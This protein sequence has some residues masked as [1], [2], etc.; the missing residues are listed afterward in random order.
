LTGTYAVSMAESNNPGQTGHYSAGGDEAHVLADYPRLCLHRS[1]MRSF[2]RAIS[3][4]SGICSRVLK[5][6]RPG[7]FTRTGLRVEFKSDDESGSRTYAYAVTVR[8]AVGATLAPLAA[9]KPTTG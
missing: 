3:P 2:L 5:R 1:R 9:P 8:C 6:T 7:T 4:T